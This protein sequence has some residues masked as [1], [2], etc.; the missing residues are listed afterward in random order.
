[1]GHPLPPLPPL[2]PPSSSSSSST[3]AAA[4]AS[5]TIT[6]RRVAPAGE[7][8]ARGTVSHSFVL[9]FFLFLHEWM[10]RHGAAGL[11]RV[12]AGAP[13]K[14]R[15]S[16]LEGGAAERDGEHGQIFNAAERTW[17]PIPDVMKFPQ[18]L[19]GGIMEIN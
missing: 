14:A 3:S 4:A 12:K 13:Q 7:K 10:M 17:C 9:F 2:P 19:V 6:G 11:R 16:T 1:M 18:S 8:R 5:D 15:V